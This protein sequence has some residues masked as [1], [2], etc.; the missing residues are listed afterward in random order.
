M[1]TPGENEYDGFDIVAAD[2]LSEHTE[3]VANC[4]R[5]M[6]A[7]L[8]ELLRDTARAT[9]AVIFGLIGMGL[10]IRAR[11]FEPC[12]ECGAEQEEPQPGPY[13]CSRCA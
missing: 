12:C 1:R 3:N 2:F 4:D 5:H 8:G 6:I 10:A 13:L 7:P 9:A 11:G